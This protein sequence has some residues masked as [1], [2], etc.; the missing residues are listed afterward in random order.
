MPKCPVSSPV[1]FAGLSGH[2]SGRSLSRSLQRAMVG[3]DQSSA[4]GPTQLDIPIGK[5][6]MRKSNLLQALR[7]LLDPSL[8]GVARQLGADDFWDGFEGPF[9][10]TEVR[11]TVELSDFDGDKAAMALLGDFLVATS[12]KGRRLTYVYRPRPSRSPL[13]RSRLRGCRAWGNRDDQLVGRDVLR[14]VSIRILPALRDAEGASAPR[15][16]AGTCPAA[17]RPSSAVRDIRSTR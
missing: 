2:Y 15:R 6:G 7:L 4:V 17:C 1:L 13:E 14:H 3:P 12:F 8:P 16:S 9:G 10:K 5:N 11:V